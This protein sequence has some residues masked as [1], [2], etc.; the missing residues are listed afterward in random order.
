METPRAGRPVAVQHV[1]AVD[2]FAYGVTGADIH[3]FENGLPLY[4]LANWSRPRAADPEWLRE[5]PSR[6]LNA[7][8]RVAPFTGRDEELGLL[9]QWRDGP[10]ARLAVRWLD[11]PGGQG[12]TRLMQQFADES[13]AAG[14]KVIEAFHGPDADRPEPGAHDLTLQD[15]VGVLLVA[16]YADR[17]LITNLTWLFKNALLHRPGVPTRVLLVARSAD[18]WPAVR[19]ILDTH[20]AATSRQRLGPLSA[21]AGERLAMFE[22]ARGGF[23]RIYA[24][25]DPVAAEFPG[26]IGDPEFGLTLAVQ[27]AALVT[28]DASSGA[29]AD[30]VPRDVGG[31]T[32][33]LLN[34]E[35]LHWRRLYQ[36]GLSASGADEGYRAEPETMNQAVFVAALTG[37]VTSADGA[38]LLKHAGLREPARVV[39][40][41]AVPYPPPTTGYALEPLYPDRLAEDFLA[42]T[43]PGH[44]ADYPA[45]PWARESVAA[46]VRRSSHQGAAPPW[47]RRGVLF[48]AAAAERWSHVGP[49]CLYPLLAADP[50]LAVDAGSPALV[51]LAGLADVE[52]SLLAAV[53]SC[54]PRDRHSELDP[55]IAVLTERLFSRVVAQQDDQTRADW[56]LKLGL[57]CANAGLFARSLEHSRA[58]VELRRRLAAADSERHLPALA[59]SL[60]NL[61]NQYASVGGRDA[62][63]DAA[64]EAAAIYR[65]LTAQ[66]AATHVVGLA[67]ALNAFSSRLAEVNQRGEALAAAEESLRLLREAGPEDPDM[68]HF[69]ATALVNLGS[70]LA[71]A[72]RPQEALAPARDAVAAYRRLAAAAPEQYLHEF[73]AALNNLTAWLA[74]A[75]RRRDAL[76]PITEA[77]QVYRRLAR[78]NP[79]AFEPDLAMAL[80]NLGNEWALVGRY[81]EA[82]TAGW[83]AVAIRRELARTDPEAHLADLA[84]ALSNVGVSLT[85]A[86]RREAAVPPSREAVEIYRALV[87]DHRSAHLPGLAMALN[88]LGN[89]LAEIGDMPDAI[90]ASH[91]AVALRRELVDIDS[92]AHLADLAASLNNLGTRLSALGAS[93]AVDLIEESIAIFHRLAAHNPSAYEPY[94][95]TALYTFAQRLALAGRAE[96]ALSAA[97][98]SLAIRRRLAEAEPDAYRAAL[99]DALVSCGARLVELRRPE[100]SLD[101]TR[102]AVAVARCLPEVVLAT[103]MSRLA[104]ALHCFAWVRLACGSE[105]DV[106]VGAVEESVE[107]YRALTDRLPFFA[108]DLQT[109]VATRTNIHAVRGRQEPVPGQVAGSPAAVDCGGAA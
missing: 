16:D 61:S 51:S 17:W 2:G 37:T 62:A 109:A 95:A 99:C 50:Q 43:V 96:D 94:L 49:Q 106:A 31:L 75:G 32:M 11:G 26:R 38:S 64:R 100:R 12:K 15:A 83:E 107:L 25:D 87:V 77:V 18:P 88:N 24:I 90:A 68:A 74:L 65:E 44:L 23:A 47:S 45:Q 103:D 54:F 91:E 7:R 69:I 41:H 20:E 13:S 8:R 92:S 76:S 56:H 84:M 78:T 5:L 30:A 98:E 21:Q 4:L 9:A 59:V 81:D 89:R 101:L 82:V 102:D 46:V 42:L 66:D 36:D 72:G 39:R 22:A 28:V 93:D 35:Q 6:M 58:G 1:T 10:T 52:T 86:G 71:E 53:E 3:V 40:D 48:L 60:A 73:A 80:N 63:L 104:T 33:F 55:G 14:W 108:T 105:L 34:R 57:R 97:E 29:D 27:M 19:A 85:E 70:R 67:V 79:A